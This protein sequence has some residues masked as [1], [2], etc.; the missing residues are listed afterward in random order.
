MFRFFKKKKIREEK[1]DYWKTIDG[2]K[3]YSFKNL[4]VIPAFRVLAIKV[5]LEKLGLGIRPSDSVLFTERLKTKLAE[6][7]SYEDAE[8][9][10]RMALSLIELAGHYEYFLKDFLSTRIMLSTGGMGIVIDDEPVDEFSEKYNKI[11]EDLLE[12]HS[13]VQSFFLSST[14]KL[15]KELREDMSDLRIENYLTPENRFREK[16]FYSAIQQPFYRELWSESML[17]LSGLVKDLDT[18][19]KS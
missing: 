1:L 10:N 8:D 2:H 9:K 19:L 16:L 5:S 15:I 6:L 11:K 18:N 4:D 12:K 14:M 13:E 7:V 17:K 3:I